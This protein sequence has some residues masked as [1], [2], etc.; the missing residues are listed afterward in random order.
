MLNAPTDL[1]RSQQLIQDSERVMTDA[2]TRIER[3][4]VLITRGEAQAVARARA[5]VTSEETF[6]EGTVSH[7]SACPWL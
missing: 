3:S 4:R 7:A 1:H 6:Q 5:A 2:T